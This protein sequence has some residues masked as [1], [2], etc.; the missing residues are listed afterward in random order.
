MRVI[1]H[2]DVNNAFLSWT[3]VDLLKKGEKVDIRTIEAVIGGDESMRHGIVLAKSPVAK[4]RGVKTAETLRDAKRKCHQLKVYPP[5]Y[6]LY[7][8]M[9]KAMFQ[10]ILKYTPDIEVLSIDECFIDY[11]K[12]QNLYGDPISFAHR[13]KDEIYHTLGFTV[14]IGIANN[15]LCAKMASDFE[16]PNKVHTL[17]KEEVEEKMYPLP[18]GD[19]YGVGK[20]TSQKLI[21]LNIHT[22]SDLAHAEESFLKKYFKNQALPLIWKARGIDDSEVVVTVEESKGISN[23]T[24]F[25]YNLIKEEVIFKNLQALIENVCT[26]LRKSNRFAYVVGVTIRDK[27]FKTYSHQKRMYNATSNSEEIFKVAKEL[28]LELWNE[29]PVR[30]LGVSLTGLTSSGRRQ[31]SLFEEEETLEK[32]SELD[33]VVDQL[34]KQYG[35]DIIKKASLVDNNIFKKYD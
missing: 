32:N 13:L 6:H 19:L 1:M 26:T 9:S 2:I 22:V 25:S 33:K 23:S 35:S 15:K 24:T 17:W 34:K 4:G 3:A 5:D 11:T 29:E 27:N 28:F 16:K 8:R 12:V 18:I 7:S 21:D 31:L 30:L 20:R 14:N 10:I